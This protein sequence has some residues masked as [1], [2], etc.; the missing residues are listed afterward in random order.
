MEI[1]L[2]GTQIKPLR[3]KL[4][5]EQN[6][7]CKLCSEEL[8]NNEAVLDHCHSS[9]KIRG[10]IHRTCNVYLGKIE[11]NMRRFRITEKRLQNIV[12]GLIEYRNDL[13]DEIHPTYGKKKTR[14]KVKTI[15]K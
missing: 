9:G 6:Y 3:E 12:H 2:K 8:L 5:E 14:K 11:N 7:T 13:R 1:K 4:L 15:D 10:V